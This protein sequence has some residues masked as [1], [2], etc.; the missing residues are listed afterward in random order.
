MIT[1]RP[2]PR[3]HPHR[4]FVAPF[5]IPCNSL[6]PY[7]I[8]FRPFRRDKLYIEKIREKSWFRGKSANKQAV[9]CRHTC[10]CRVDKAS[11]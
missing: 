3:P 6:N 9:S 8:S 7:I 5:F 4:N 10:T 11:S 1:T 2:R